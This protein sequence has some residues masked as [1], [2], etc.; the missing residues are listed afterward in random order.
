MSVPELELVL[1]SNVVVRLV[2][3]KENEIGD[4]CDYFF[5]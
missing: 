2:N 4:R 5:F 3:Q 1:F